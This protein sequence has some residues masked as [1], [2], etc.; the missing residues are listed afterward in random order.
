MQE[1]R[2]KI[3][4]LSKTIDIIV[5]LASGP[6]SV[7]DLAEITGVSKP[8]TYRILHTLELGNFVTK[9]NAQKEFA[10]STF[11]L[12]LTRQE[13]R[14]LD[15]VRILVSYMEMINRKY[16]ETIN[17]G[18]LTGKRVNYLYSIESQQRLR[19]GNPLHDKDYLHSTALGKALLSGFDDEQLKKIVPKLDL[20]Q[21]TSKTITTIPNL[22]LAISKI[23][24]IGY[25]IDDQENEIGS[26]CIAVALTE[27][28][29]K[30]V[31]A[32]SVSGPVSR[33]TSE[34]VRLIGENLKLVAKQ[35]K[36]KLE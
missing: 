34:K 25:A 21:Q 32:L 24:K 3:Q 27:K 5:S 8:A 33:M 15:L 10:L 6:K 23:R 12:N 1:D 20:R 4:V 36:S 16:D 26:R 14:N 18:I 2:E 7:R 30:T 13:G 11:F 9:K 31:A 29:G 28:S 19:S 22:M 35:V 17:L